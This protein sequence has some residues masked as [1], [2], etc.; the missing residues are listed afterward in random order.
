M[1]NMGH[2]WQRDHF[3]CISVAP[4]HRSNEPLYNC[5]GYVVLVC[6]PH[7]AL[8]L[9]YKYKYRREQTTDMSLIG[10]DPL[11]TNILQTQSYNKYHVPL[12]VVSRYI[13]FKSKWART[14]CGSKYSVNTAKYDSD[15]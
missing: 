8:V 15:I 13:V 4:F 1:V 2:T 9:R 6:N 7:A 3:Y 10:N 5:D 11:M 14:C 12:S